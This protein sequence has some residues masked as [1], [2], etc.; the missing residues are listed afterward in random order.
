MHD[1][2]TWTTNTFLMINL[3]ATVCENEFFKVKKVACTFENSNYQYK[4][5]L[6]VYTIF[7]SFS[8]TT[9]LIL[10]RLQQS[11]KIFLSKYFIRQQLNGR[12]TYVQ[13]HTYIIRWRKWLPTDGLL[14][15]FISRYYNIH[16]CTTCS[17][18]TKR[19]TK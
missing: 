9:T 14:W 2:R 1:C 4:F 5:S 7:C 16:I 12:S 15:A 19:L 3:W 6:F 17:R 11:S 8:Y 10:M 13:L 18:D